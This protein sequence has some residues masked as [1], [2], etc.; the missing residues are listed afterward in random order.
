MKRRQCKNHPQKEELFTHLTISGSVE[1]F[2]SIATENV[3][4]ENDFWP[5]KNVH[6]PRSR[7]L[8]FIYVEWI[9]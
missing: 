5:T 2:F 4:C 3:N 9:T 6:K 7:V 8:S 1:S